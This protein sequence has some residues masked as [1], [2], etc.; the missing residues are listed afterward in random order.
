MRRTI[1]GPLRRTQETAR[2]ALLSTG[3][4]GADIEIEPRLREIDY[5]LWEGKSSD[6]IRGMGWGE[7]LT[8]WEADSSWPSSGA[9]PLSAAAYVNGFLSVLDD[10]RR[11]PASPTLIVSSNGVFKLFAVSLDGQL[12]GKMGT[13]HL[14]LVSLKASEPDVLCWNLAPDAFVEWTR[15]NLGPVLN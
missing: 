15:N 1:A 3:M 4:A 10:A 8:A 11:R 2:L 9:W 5:G 6:E 7:E 14:S 13:G 12:P